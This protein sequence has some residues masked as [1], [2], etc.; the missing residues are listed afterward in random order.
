MWTLKIKSL[1]MKKLLALIPLIILSG[2]VT[3]TD[4]LNRKNEADWKHTGH[5]PNKTQIIEIA[6]Y[7]SELN[8]LLLKMNEAAQVNFIEYNT[9][10]YQAYDATF[11]D[12]SP[13]FYTKVDAEEYADANNFNKDNDPTGHQY[14]VR[15]VSHRFEVRILND[16]QNELLYTSNNLR[17]AESY[18]NHYKSN[19]NDLIL[20]D[21][22]EQNITSYNTP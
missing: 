17:D 16:V 12:V 11:P 19:H 15:E 7:N 8:N 5:P 22:I 9:K 1:N 18:M 20:Y 13:I 4:F 6:E 10:Y 2:C 3:V 14:V 21:L